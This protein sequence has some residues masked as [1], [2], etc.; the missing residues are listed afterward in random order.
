MPSGA[1][2]WMSNRSTFVQSGCPAIRDGVLMLYANWMMAR[3]GT[4]IIVTPPCQLTVTWLAPERF[5]LTEATSNTA[6]ACARA[7]ADTTATSTSTPPALLMADLVMLLLTATPRRLAGFPFAGAVG[8][9]RTARDGLRL[10]DLRLHRLLLL[11]AHRVEALSQR[12]HEV[13]DF[14]R[15]G[16]LGGDDFLAGDLG[17]DD[18]PQPLAVLVLV[19]LQVQL[20][21][22]RRDHLPGELHLLRP[23]L[24]RDGV[25]LL[26]FVDAAN[27]RVVMQRVHHEAFLLRPHGH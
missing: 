16:H 10:L 15:L 23:D 6:G 2:A 18:L 27:F 17:V 8:R 5:T 3:S 21:V 26:D 7:P 13:D 1:R 4:L 24:R 9:F 20:A 11:G 25:Q 19:V 14:R 12:L 22:E